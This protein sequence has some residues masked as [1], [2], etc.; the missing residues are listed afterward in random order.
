MLKLTLGCMY[1]GKTSALIKESS[2]QGQFIVID[3]DRGLPHANILSSH[4]NIALRC[5]KTSDLSALNIDIFDAIFINEA[6]FFEGLVT[7]V[8][9]CLYKHKSIYVYALDG[10]FKQESFGEI[11]QLIPMCDEYV[12]LY[13]LC[14]CGKHAPFSKRLSE[15][16]EQY[17]PHDIYRPSCRR[18]LTL[19][20][21]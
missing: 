12:K 4:D 11:I 15:K 6:Q 8:K 7:F 16:K 3:Y 1:A 5:I 14:A 9:E 18:C 19:P 13:A 20:S 21:V 10:D 17:L 2:L